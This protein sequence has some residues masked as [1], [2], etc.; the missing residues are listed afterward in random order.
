MLHDMNARHTISRLLACG[1][2]SALVACQSLPDLAMRTDTA[3]QLADTKRWQALTLPSGTFTLQGFGPAQGKA[4]Q[5]LS[6][7]LEGDGLAWLTPVQPS[8][9]PTP[10]KPLALQ[11]ALA[12]PEGQAAYLARPCQYQA[13]PDPLCRQPYWT[14]ARFAEEAVD[15]SNQAI[16]QLKA[17]Y[18]A[19]RLILVGYS[20]GGAMAAL[21]ASRRQDVQ[22]LVTV[23]GNLETQQWVRLHRISP[24]SGSLNPGDVA[25]ALQATP[26]W[27]L[28]GQQDTVV[29]EQIAQAFAKRAAARQQAIV[30]IP[31]FDHSCCWA[32]QWPGLW[33]KLAADKLPGQP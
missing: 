13:T 15:A 14:H 10:L 23:A 26:Q 12:Q 30:V 7:Y 17:R 32:E 2:L 29:P 24:L 8:F 6:I 11:L 5:I 4:Q 28:V 25:A 21:V 31:G 19:S 1:L 33:R 27:H 22:A 9:D 16:S 3:R 20:G 18:G